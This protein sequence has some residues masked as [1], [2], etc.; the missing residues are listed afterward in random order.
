LFGCEKPTEIL[1]RAAQRFRAAQ[2]RNGD[3]PGEVKNM[4][5]YLSLIITAVVLLTLA[6]MDLKDFLRVRREKNS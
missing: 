3:E 2:A 4:G 1:V 5:R 6:L